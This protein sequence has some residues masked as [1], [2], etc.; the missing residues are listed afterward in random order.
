M[1]RNIP[2]HA[3][4][5]SPN[6]AVIYARISPRPQESEIGLEKQAA[7]MRR[8]AEE[9]D[10]FIDGEYFDD[11]ISG[12]KP[13]EKRPG[14]LKAI[15]H[16]KRIRGVLLIYDVFRLTRASIEAAL[17]LL[18]E[19][20]DAGCAIV[21]C[22]GHQ[23]DMTTPMGRAFVNMILTIGQ[24]Q[25]EMTSESTKQALAFRRERGLTRPSFGF[26][27]KRKGTGKNKRWFEIE[28]EY[29]QR[30]IAWAQWREAIGQGFEQMR[31]ELHLRRYRR[32]PTRKRFERLISERLLERCVHKLKEN[33]GWTWD[34]PPCLDALDFHVH[35]IWQSDRGYAAALVGGVRKELLILPKY[36]VPDRDGNWPHAQS[37]IAEPLLDGEGYI[38]QGVGIAELYGFREQAKQWG[39]MLKT[40]YALA[41]NERGQ[42]MAKLPQQWRVPEP[43][44]LPW[45]YRMQ[46]WRPEHFAA[47]LRK[48]TGPLPLHHMRARSAF[49]RFEHLYEFNYHLPW[50]ETGYAPILV[51]GRLPQA[52]VTKMVDCKNKKRAAR[53]E[54]RLAKGLD[55]AVDAGCCRAR[56]EDPSDEAADEA[57][58][59]S[60]DVYQQRVG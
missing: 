46:V 59:Q 43:K 29:E 55:D 35:R 52:M 17:P 16:V 60:D 42:I 21:S 53:R 36:V 13:L 30:I 3:D 26:R 14:L 33:K 2:L 20:N 1:P 50:V 15:E 7:D 34:K 32:L 11:K 49:I 5:G 24:L 10:L 4:D 56:G 51:E 58:R 8:V 37:R 38:R 57:S 40:E 39:Y 6:F 31:D 27:L 44:R 22:A 12:A 19:I 18:H 23:I 25:R 47:E 41:R 28:H 48:W 54:A 9:R 45:M